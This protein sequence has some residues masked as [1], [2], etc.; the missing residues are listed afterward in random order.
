L[1]NTKKEKRRLIKKSCLAAIV[2]LIATEVHR[3]V[4][5]SVTNHLIQFIS[6]VGYVLCVLYTFMVFWSV[7]KNVQE[8]HV[9][10]TLNKWLTNEKIIN[11]LKDSKLNDFCRPHHEFDLIFV[12]DSYKISLLKEYLAE[13]KMKLRSQDVLALKKYY[14]DEGK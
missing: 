12:G 4:N 6:F 8:I 13:L 2:W 5:T 11:L 10:E 14:Q 9:I 1:I 3:L 7:S